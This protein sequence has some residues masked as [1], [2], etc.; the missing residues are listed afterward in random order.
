M[1]NAAQSNPGMK[2]SPHVVTA[3]GRD[4]GETPAF[5][6]AVDPMNTGVWQPVEDGSGTADRSGSVTAPFPDGPGRWKQT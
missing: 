2:D 1:S 4:M 5:W 3:A 6:S